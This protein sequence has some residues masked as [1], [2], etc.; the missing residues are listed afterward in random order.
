MAR[1]IDLTG[2]DC[3]EPVLRVFRELGRLEAG[4]WLEARMDSEACAYT[5]VEMIN[6]SGVG[7]ASVSRERDGVYVVRVLRL[8]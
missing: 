7:A 1:S 3:P 2:L 8:R 4:E 5:A 6:R